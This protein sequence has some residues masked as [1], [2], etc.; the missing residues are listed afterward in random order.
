[1]EKPVKKELKKE[2]KSFEALSKD[3]L[4]LIRGGNEEQPPIGNG[5]DENG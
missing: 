2:E 4:N 3:A 1:M 5:D